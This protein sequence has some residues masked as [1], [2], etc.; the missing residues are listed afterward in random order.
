MRGLGSFRRLGIGPFA[1]TKR[2]RKWI[3]RLF[4]ITTRSIR[5]FRQDRPEDAGLLLIPKESELATYKTRLEDSGYV[6]AD[7]RDFPERESAGASL[8]ESKKPSAWTS[9]ALLRRG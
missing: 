8:R 2:P 4:D 1:V 5:Y 9:K 6:V 3:A 7:S